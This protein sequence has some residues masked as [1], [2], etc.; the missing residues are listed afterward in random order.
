MSCREQ[1]SS[2]SEIEMRRTFR[3]WHLQVV[4]VLPPGAQ[5]SGILTR[6]L[7]SRA[8]E[9]LIARCADAIP[10]VSPGGLAAGALRSRDYIEKAPS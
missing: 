7:V 4:G 6:R 1:I 2:A 8:G 10:P 9:H 3:S 5:R